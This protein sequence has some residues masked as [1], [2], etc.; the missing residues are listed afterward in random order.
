M[1]RL[2]ADIHR[3]A[4]AGW[5]AQE[6]LV[7]A[8][9]RFRR[10]VGFDGWCGLTLDP[11]TLIKTG[12]VDASEVPAGLLPRLFH[13]EYREADVSQFATLARRRSPVAVLHDETGG[14]P[15]SSARFREVAAPAGYRHEL[16]LV[17][18]ERARSW[19]AFTLLRGPGRPF[20]RTESQLLAQLSV[21]LAAGLRAAV[22]RAGSTPVAPAGGLVL[23]GPGHEVQSLT[24]GAGRALGIGD[25]G[26]LPPEAHAVAARA[27][28][29]ADGISARSWSPT[30][31]WRTLTG[32][33]LGPAQVAISVEQTRPEHLAALVIDAYGLSAREREITERVLRGYS[34]RRI[35]QALYLSPYTVQDH[36]KAIFDKAGVRSR[37]DLVAALAGRHHADAALPGPG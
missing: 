29:A 1:E 20:S 14:R 33:R 6:L 32:W 28:R 15:E 30:A 25:G 7:Q 4:A 34:T 26:A 24:P 27:W 22:A 19:G 23:L 12:G 11:T 10:A 16:R 17:L 21:P 18:R 9:A 35:A 37:R 36:L 31:G 8:A 3:L 2:I 5:P 13:L